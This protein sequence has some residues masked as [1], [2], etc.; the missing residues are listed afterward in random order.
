MASEAWPRSSLA[1]TPRMTAQDAKVWRRVWKLTSS[2]ST[3]PGWTRTQCNNLPSAGHH[4]LQEEMNR[5]AVAAQ[6]RWAN[7]KK[8]G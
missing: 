5:M 1:V 4:G 2:A 7:V 8:K 3:V 6:A